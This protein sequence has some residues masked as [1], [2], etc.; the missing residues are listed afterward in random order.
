MSKYY[1]CVGAIFKNE[2][3]ILKEWIEHYYFHGVDHIY[4]INDNSTDNYLEILEPYIN[5]NKITLYHTSNEFVEVSRQS[6]YYNYFFKKH[7]DETIWLGIFDLDEFLYSPND[8]NIKNIIKNY[9][10]YDQL[11]INWV[12]FGSSGFKTQPDNVVQNFIY[13][14]EYNS[15]E[16]GP[17]GRYNSI[18]T[19]VKTSKCISLNIHLHHCNGVLKNI[20][21]DEKNTPLLIN[22]YA[23]QSKDY[24]ET[25]KMTRGDC[26]KYYD[27][28]GW[29]RDLKLFE[30][31]DVN[32]IK[33]ERLKEQ[34]KKS[35]T[36]VLTSCNR[37]KE[38]TITLRSFFKFNK[39]PVKFIIIDDSGINGCIDNAVKEIPDY[40][41]K[42]IIYNEVNIGQC[43]SI[44]KAYKMVDTEYIFHSEDDWEFTDYNFIEES[45]EILK[46]DPKIYLVVPSSYSNNITTLHKHP[47]KPTVYN[48]SYKLMDV[49]VERTNIWYGFTFN[50]SLRRTSD[51][52]I[53]SPY[54][55]YFDSPLCNV[56][57]IEQALNQLYH[58]KGFVFAITLNSNG[59][60]KHIGGDNPCPRNYE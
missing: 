51:A 60:V 26:D 59:F 57:G 53:F 41:E 52:I 42:K 24:W 37:P 46:Q 13:R 27:S 5:N 58:K 38:L 48:N 3:H 54:E 45:L 15:L 11:E 23:V 8:I 10:L 49:L 21:F 30:E 2:S 6:E 7:L 44:D 25:I 50:P 28:Q 47:I 18:K 32:Q 43:R 34:N 16:N 36:V 20:S 14:G 12:H 31:M 33:D 22:H 4:L 39:Y 55:Q 19:I 1:F 17:K 35:V 56:G 9:E 29:E 40:V